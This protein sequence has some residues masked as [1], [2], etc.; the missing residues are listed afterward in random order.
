MDG[1]DGS[2][3]AFIGKLNDNVVAVKVVFIYD[4][5]EYEDEDDEEDE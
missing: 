5:D 2:Y 1:G 4:A 3:S